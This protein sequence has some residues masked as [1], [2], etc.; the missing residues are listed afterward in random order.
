MRISLSLERSYSTDLSI[1]I[2]ALRA[3][4]TI[5][6][7]LQS[8][9]KVMPVKS[10]EEALKLAETHNATLAGERDGAK[11]EGFDVGNSPIDIKTCSGDILVLTTTNGTRVL[12]SMQSQVLIGTF[13]NAKA[14]AKKSVE[15]ADNHIEVVMAG[16]K[17][18]FVIEDFL[19]AG[20]IISHLKNH[21]LDEMALASVM[22]SHDKNRVNESVRNSKSAEGLRSLGLEKDIEYSLQRDIYDTVPIYKNGI[23]KDLK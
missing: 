14:V 21:E 9:N 7:A 19:A 4:A 8:Y 18:K 23:I 12:E 6:T 2:D 11:I 16:V 5:I 20:E 15:L 1:M 13:L 10:I 22:A 3:S 17:G